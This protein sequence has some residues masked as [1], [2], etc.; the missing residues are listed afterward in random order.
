VIGL[1]LAAAFPEATVD[2]LDNSAD[3]LALARE[4]AARLGL[5]ERVRF[6]ESDLLLYVSHVY[7]LIVANLPYVPAS[8]RGTLSREVLR[9]PE[10]AL[11]G[12]ERGHE[13]ICRL[14]SAAPP[15]LKPGGLLALEI[16]LGQSETLTAFLAEKNFHDITAIQDYSRVTRFLFARYG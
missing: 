1:S 15:H 12:G 13:V 10:Q 5:L 3:A 4:N 8:E 16:G 11:F 6:I 14:I 9:D 7:D 2:A